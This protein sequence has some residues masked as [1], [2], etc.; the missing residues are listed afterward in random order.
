MNSFFRVLER[1]LFL[2]AWLFFAGS[3]PLYGAITEVWAV[4]DGEKVYRYQGDHLSRGKNSV[5]DGKT[6]RL[7]GLY[8]EVLA[9]QVIVEADS[10]GAEAVEVMVEPPLNKA[11]GKRIGA[12]VPLHYGP[13]GAVEVF[14]EHYLEVKHHTKVMTKTNWLAS[15]EA[16]LPK[17]MTGWI[18]DALIPPGARAG[19]GGQPL[20]IPRVK[21][22]VIRHHEVEIVPTA[23]RQN[24]GFWVDLYLPRDREYPPG[25]TGLRADV[26][27]RAESRP[28]EGA[29]DC[30]VGGAQGVQ[31]CVE[32]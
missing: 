12:E 16:S 10:L 17:R 26:A 1:L 14:S 19:R 18:P 27:G 6:I 28:R 23:L 31:R 4:G 15:N 32:R 29:R 20:D 25:T 21:T 11:G 30:Q 7:K 9:F 5:W 22:R 2:P 3:A 8:N 24:Q 13:G